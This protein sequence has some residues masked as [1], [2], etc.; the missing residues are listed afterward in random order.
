MLQEGKAPLLLA[1]T[2]CR[3]DVVKLLL[4][5]KADI[6]AKDKH[7]ITP[8][9]ASSPE[10]RASLVNAIVKKESLL[11]EAVIHGHIMG[12]GHLPM[13]VAQ[14]IAAKWRIER[15]KDFLESASSN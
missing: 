2:E 6:H 9:A 12:I 1:A 15:H 8:L 3:A 14:L 7:G 13:D 11:V 5:H 4:K 10:L